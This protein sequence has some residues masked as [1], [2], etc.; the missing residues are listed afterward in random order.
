MSQQDDTNETPRTYRI[1]QLGPPRDR[2]GDPVRA[3]GRGLQQNETVTGFD[4]LVLHHPG[5][6]RAARMENGVVV[7]G[8]DGRAFGYVGGQLQDIE[9]QRNDRHGRFQTRGLQPDQVL[10]KKDF[11]LSHPDKDSMSLEGRNVEVPAPVAGVIGARRDDQ[12]LV[13]ILDREG[14]EVIARFRHMR[15]IEI[16]VGDHVAYGQTLGTQSNV[17]TRPV[18]VHME[19]DTR[20]YPQFRNYVDDL[21]S[22]RLPVEAEHRVGVQPQPVVDEGTLRLGESSS[23]IRDLQ[24]VMDREGYRAAGGGPL[25]RD[26]VYRI[27]MQGALLDFQRDHGIPQTGDIDRATLQFAPAARPRETD[28]QD[29]LEMGHPMP[30]ATPE[31]QRAPGHPDHPDHRPGLPEQ[32]EAPVNQRSRRTGSTGDLQLDRLADALY[33]DDEAGMSRVCA[34]IERSPD[35][36]A[37]IAQGRETLATQERERDQQGFARHNQ[38]PALSLG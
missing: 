26:G 4:S 1:Q 2:D 13:D 32:L 15:N 23:R 36:Q 10:V 25:D 34:E 21:A 11:I 30:S 38:E 16:N 8:K 6:N 14:G 37:L 18:H 3:Q 27:G 19:M 29:Y 31:P 20:Y 33:A 7:D 35:V 12:G 24:M 22:G 5:D 17:A 9:I 28:R